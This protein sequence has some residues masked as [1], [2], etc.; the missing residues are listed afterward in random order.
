M[1]SRT[2]TWSSFWSYVWIGCV[3]ISS[4]VIETEAGCG[5]LLFIDPYP[6]GLSNE[7]D[8]IIKG[9]LQID[10]TTTSVNST[11]VTV[12]DP[13]FVIGDVTSSRVVTAPV[14]TG[15]STITIDSVVGINTGD[16]ISNHTS[17]PNSGV[18][19]VTEVNTTNK[20]I[21]IEGST[22]AGIT[23]TSEL[24]I[25]HAYDTNTDRGIAFNYN[26][27]VG[28]ANNKTGYFGYVDGDGSR[29]INSAV[30][31]YKNEVKNKQFPKAK[32]SFAN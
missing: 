30:K 2:C 19:T 8:V 31:K 7:G 27:G 10:G 28:T 17:L 5:D 12:N 11:A 18:T 20:V 1:H 24:T 22:T 15:V 4:N 25:T 6:D 14:T 29:I 16:I 32:H 26:T 23:T 13:I 21:T 3:G 9:N